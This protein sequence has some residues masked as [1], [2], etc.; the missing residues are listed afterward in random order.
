[1]TDAHELSGKHV[2][3]EA[4][5]ELRGGKRHLASDYGRNHIGIPLELVYYTRGLGNLFQRTIQRD[6]APL[7]SE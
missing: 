5:Q 6:P 3:E 1:M 4:P 7:W 2:Q